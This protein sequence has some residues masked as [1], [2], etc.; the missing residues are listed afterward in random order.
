[1]IILSAVTSSEAFSDWQ[2]WFALFGLLMT[3]ANIRLTLQTHKEKQEVVQIKNEIQTII[4]NNVSAEAVASVVINDEEKIKEL[5]T[6]ITETLIA[7]KTPHFIVDDSGTMS[8]TIPD[9]HHS[10]KFER[11]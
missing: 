4:N 3:F 11:K 7:R 8:I 6:V 9:S 2:F 10:L 5:A 1:M